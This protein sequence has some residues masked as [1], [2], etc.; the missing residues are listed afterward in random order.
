MIQEAERCVSYSIK[1]SVYQKP[2]VPARLHHSSNLNMP[3]V[4]FDHSH[5]NHQMPHA[6]TAIM[7]YCSRRVWIS[8][9]L[10]EADGG[11]GTAYDRP[12][13][14]LKTPVMLL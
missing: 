10:A 6:Y 9:D 14:W 8:L 3:S 11:S 2:T 13:G 12:P 4:R 7:E 1:T 5:Q